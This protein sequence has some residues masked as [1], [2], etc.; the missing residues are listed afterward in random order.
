M[1]LAQLTAWC[2]DRFGKHRR[3]GQHAATRPFD[4]PWVVMDATRARQAFGWEPE[5]T[6]PKILDEIAA[7]VE[8][9]PDWLNMAGA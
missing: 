7:H 8:A 4:V 1:S 9:H 3:R 5:M 2:D 6:L